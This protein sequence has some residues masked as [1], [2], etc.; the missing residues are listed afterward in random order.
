VTQ[1]FTQG[2]ITASNNPMDVAIN[3]RGFFRMSQGGSISYTRNGQFQMDK[4]NYIVDARGLQLTG[5]ALNTTTGVLDTSTPVPLQL[6]TGDQTP[7]VTGG[8]TTNP[9]VS[10]QFNLD[11]R[12]VTIVTPSM[13]AAAT[14]INAAVAG[15]T[16][17]A[18]A[19]LPPAANAADAAATLAL[20][21]TA[22]N[23]AAGLVAATP[24]DAK[25]VAMNAALAAISAATTASTAAGANGAST[26]LAATTSTAV[27]LA[28]NTPGVGK[29]FNYQDP[30]TFNQSTSLA[31]YDQQGNPYSQTL[32]FKKTADNI[33]EVYSTLTSSRTD[34]SGGVTSVTTPL[35]PPG[36]ADA[37]CNPHIQR[38]WDACLNRAGGAHCHRSGRRV[39]PDRNRIQFSSQFYRYEPVWCQFRGECAQSG[40]IFFRQIDRHLD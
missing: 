13:N 19:P 38:Q 1:Q 39:R 5:F 7:R 27:T 26:L 29:D 14:S 22:A 10:G 12:N 25:T 8:A 35:P 31:I 34:A 21:T 17:A 32:Y 37:R 3:G 24:P 6:N 9:G 36:G 40:R 11:S 16:A 23:T 4:N 33:W 20:I 28:A 2:N 30:T 15:V 18:T